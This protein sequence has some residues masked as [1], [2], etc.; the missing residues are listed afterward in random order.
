MMRLLFLLALLFPALLSAADVPPP[1]PP[2]PA[3]GASSMSGNMSGIDMPPVIPGAM[4]DSRY[5]A[6]KKF[7]EDD[8]AEIQRGAL[9]QFASTQRVRQDSHSLRLMKLFT[10]LVEQ[11]KPA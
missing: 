5:N 11:H 1:P 2:I 7:F 4:S 10:R 3:S 8:D 6:L 9:C